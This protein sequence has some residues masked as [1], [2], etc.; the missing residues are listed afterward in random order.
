MSRI[1]WGAFGGIEGLPLI[2]VFSNVLVF[3]F[4]LLHPGLI[5]LLNLSHDALWEGQWWRLVTFVFVPPFTS[6]SSL[7]SPTVMSVVLMFVWFLFLHTMVTALEHA[8]G[9]GRFTVYFLVGVVATALVGLLPLAGPL[10]NGYLQ[11]SFFLAF[12]TLFPHVEVLLFFI[13]PVKVKWL[14]YFTWAMLGL[15]FLLGSGLVRL[16]ILAGLVNY[17]L[18]LGPDLWDQVRLRWETF[19][20]R[21]RFRN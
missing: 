21:R 7:G 1:R 15:G 14:G 12:A 6:A 2:I 3:L 5:G 17:F 4:N 11:A 20:N 13:V 8:W 9:S 19:R 18:I 16:T 10:T